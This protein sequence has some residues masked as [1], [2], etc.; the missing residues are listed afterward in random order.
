[1]NEHGQFMMQPEY[2]TA[3]PTS[4]DTLFSFIS[5]LCPVRVERGLI[6]LG[7]L[8][9]G[10]YLVPNDLD[11][12]AA[13]FSPGVAFDATF[14]QAVLA[15]GIPCYLADPS[16]SGAPISHP[17]IDFTR[18]FL[19]LWNDEHTVTL[20]H[21]INTKLPQPGDLL[22]QMDIEGSEW[23]IMLNVSDDLLRRFR[24]IVVELHGLDHL[25]HKFGFRL[26]SAAIQRLLKHFMVVHLHPNN[27]AP[28]VVAEGL[29]IPVVLEMTLLRR[30]R[31]LPTGYAQF[32]HPLDVKNNPH[33]RDLALTPPWYRLA[34]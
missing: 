7:A 31:A 30:D 32:P 14:E 21:W 15:R 6:R 13:C 16:V 27:F 24:I 22:L 1:M 10:G 19:G 11:G 28:S 23:P 25:T 12:I 29:E 9:D 3:G 20:D 2:Y 18:A 34:M 8:A 33:G 5:S 17:L 26:I 4:R